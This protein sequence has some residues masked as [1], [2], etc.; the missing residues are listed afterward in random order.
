MNDVLVNREIINLFYD[1]YVATQYK[2]RSLYTQIKWIAVVHQ[3]IQVFKENSP[4][5]AFTLK[6]LQTSL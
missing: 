1:H 4:L 5:Y 6:A 2:N 3:I